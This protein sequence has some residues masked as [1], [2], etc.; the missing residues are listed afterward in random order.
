[1]TKKW[2]AIKHLDDSF[3]VVVV[4]VVVVGPKH[5]PNHSPESYSGHPSLN[6]RTGIITHKS[7]LFHDGSA[8]NAA[9]AAEGLRVL[10]HW[11]DSQR[12]QKPILISTATTQH[13]SFSTEN[14]SLCDPMIVTDFVR[15]ESPWLV[16]HFFLVMWAMGNLIV[17]LPFGDGWNPAHK[18]TSYENGLWHWVY[19][20]YFCFLTRIIIGF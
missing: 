15:A 16:Q 9:T 17:N 12:N 3:V 10:N 13:V 5:P 4:V 20:N 18:N 8:I 11:L 2:S 6:E 1:M 14:V 19:Q 7:W